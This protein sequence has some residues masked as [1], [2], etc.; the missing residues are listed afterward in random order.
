MVNCVSWAQNTSRTK[1]RIQRDTSNIHY[2]KEMEK[3]KLN[4]L[5]VGKAHTHT[6]THTQQQSL[7]VK[8]QGQ[9]KRKSK[10]T[11]TK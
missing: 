11:K 7:A 6:H 8:I 4:Q 3:G 2:I 10:T 5:D 1:A 9:V